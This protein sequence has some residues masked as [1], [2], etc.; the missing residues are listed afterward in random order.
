MCALNPSVCVQLLLLQQHQ[1]HLAW[2][3]AQQQQQEGPA[4]GVAAGERKRGRLALSKPATAAIAATAADRQ[5]W[6]PSSRQ[7]SGMLPAKTARKDLY[8]STPGCS[9]VRGSQGCSKVRVMP[10][11]SKV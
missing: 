11:C 7:T 3:Q 4:G 10:G 5:A 8:D 1:Q 6:K 2:Q 9:K